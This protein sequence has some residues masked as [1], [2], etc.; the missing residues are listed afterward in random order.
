MSMTR[1]ARRGAVEDHGHSP[2]RRLFAFGVSRFRKI[3]VPGSLIRLVRIPGRPGTPPLHGALA[4]RRG[5]NALLPKNRELV[6][7]LVPMLDTA[8]L[9]TAHHVFQRQ[10]EKLQCGLFTGKSSPRFD[11]LA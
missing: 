11:D 7:S 1:A 2:Q 5:L 9:P 10:V 6:Q 3:F 4:S 8:A